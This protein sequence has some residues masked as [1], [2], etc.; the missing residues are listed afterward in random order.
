MTCKCNE[1][2]S[3]IKEISIAVENPSTKEKHNDLG[4]SEDGS[5]DDLVES[6]T[7]LTAVEIER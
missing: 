6:K 1:R 4:W 2:K 7:E 5:D 3:K